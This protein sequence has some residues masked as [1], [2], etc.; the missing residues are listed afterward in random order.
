MNL[1][2][3]SI[4]LSY[5]NSNQVLGKEP[6]TF[7]VAHASL[8]VAHASFVVAPRVSRGRPRLFSYGILLRQK[9]QFFN[10]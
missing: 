3:N 10:K 7:V 4:Y 8:V 1:S 2:G 6:L 5:I 9:S